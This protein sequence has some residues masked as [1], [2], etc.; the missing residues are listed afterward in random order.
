[1]VPP[2]PECTS[3]RKIKGTETPWRHNEGMGTSLMTG[4]IKMWELGVRGKMWG[5]IKVMYR[6][7]RSAVLLDGEC[8]DAFDV[9]QGVAQ[10][11]SLSPILF[12]V[13][14][15]G[16]LKEVEQAGLGVELS[17]GSTIGGMLFAD[18]F[19]G[20][21]NSEEELQRLINVVHAYCC[22]WRLKANV[23][24]GAVVVFARELVEGSWN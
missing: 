18:D 8:S 21:S 16:L 15:N 24:K 10:G 6:V 23:S 11:C 14:I 20:V 13:F 12:S 2:I 9:Q 5:V 1:M 17:D 4:S 3:G 19:V 7:S 22:K